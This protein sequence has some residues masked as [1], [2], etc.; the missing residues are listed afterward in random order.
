MILALRALG[1]GDLLTAVPALRGLRG[2]FEGH[3][4]ALGAP[5]WLTPLIS[6]I[7]GVDRIVPVD[8]LGPAALPAATLAVNLH[9]SGPESHRLLRT[10]SPDRLWAFACPAAG[11]LDGPAWDEEDHEVQRWCR[12]LSHYDVAADPSDLTLRPPAAA[13]ADVS[14]IHPG[15]KSPSRRWP[16]ERYAAVAGRLRADGHRV[17]ITGSDRERDLAVRVATRAG[18]DESAVPRTD[19]GELAALVARA[20]VVISGDTGIAHLATAYRTPS[21]VLFGPMSPARWGPPARPQHRAIWHGTRSEPGDSPGPRVHPALLAIEP[22]EVL[23]AAREV[24]GA[25][26]AL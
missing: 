21:V 20:R 11:H 22:D 14:I 6:L 26:A 25:T 8:G 17:L 2:A 19:L 23:A 1:V 3:T 10:A 7:G 13:E 12:M 4:L 18:L 24:T 9:G 5:T 15:A 16:V